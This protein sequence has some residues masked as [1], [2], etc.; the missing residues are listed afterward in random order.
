MATNRYSYT[1]S[2]TIPRSIS[3]FVEML[4]PM[5]GIMPKLLGFSSANVSKF[6]LLNWPNANKV[7]WLTD[8]ENPKT[9]TLNDSGGI[10]DTDTTIVVTDAIFNAGD[11]IQIGD[12]KIRITAVSTTTLT[13]VSAANN[14]RGYGGTD[15]ASHS[16][17]ATVTLLFPAND[18]GGS[19]PQAYTTT[20]SVLYNYP[21]IFRYKMSVTGTRIAVQDYKTDDEMAYQFMK[22]WNENGGAGKVVKDFEDTYFKGERVGPRSSSLPASMGGFKT[23]VTS[24]TDTTGGDLTK[25]RLHSMLRDIADDGGTV[26]Y[27]MGNAFQ[28]E[29][30][31]NWYEGF[32]TMTADSK[33]GGFELESI[34]TQ[35][36]P[37]IKLLYNY[38]CP[39]DEV[40]LINPKDMGWI[41]VR[42]W[43]KK[44]LPT[45]NDAE[46][47]GLVGEFSF[48]VR[49]EQHMGYFDGLSTS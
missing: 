9:T 4:D 12:E 13:T 21:Q 37:P 34:R 11:I 18:E 26:E 32:R 14:G 45:A 2:N 6:E 7:E 19:F 48:V 10:S 31:S 23:Y 29:R 44:S 8:T 25:P 49:R 30:I 3:N 35:F 20:T 42:D 16:D 27:I 46:D 5:Q 47:M 39:S 43:E 22:L 40:H 1:D 38:R 28:V 24:H 17:G 15:A 33:L 36:M 41:P